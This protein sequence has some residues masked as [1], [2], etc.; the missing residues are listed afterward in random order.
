MRYMPLRSADKIELSY[1]FSPY[2]IK[3]SCFGLLEERRLLDGPDVCSDLGT[4]NTRTILQKLRTAIPSSLLK[5]LR[6]QSFDSF[7]C[8]NLK[9]VYYTFISHSKAKKQNKIMNICSRKW[10]QISIFYG[11]TNISEKRIFSVSPIK[12]DAM[13]ATKPAVPK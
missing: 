7:Y 6:I 5:C 2:I 11:I 4:I 10:L 3:S 12:H 13:T 1:W 9:N 8:C